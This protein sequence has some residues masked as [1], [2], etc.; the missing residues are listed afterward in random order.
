M[1]QKVVFDDAT[2]L[3]GLGAL[4]ILPLVAA[5][6]ILGTL[7]AG[8]RA[9][10]ALGEDV[11]RMLEVLA[12]QAAQAVLRAQLFEQTERLAT[13]DALTSLANRRTFQIRATQTLAQARRYG[14]AC[15][16]LMTDIDHFKAGNDTYGHPDGDVVL[17]GVAQMLREQARDTDVVA[18]YGGEE[19]AVVMPE[20]DLRGA[21][22]IAERLREAVAARVFHTEFGPVRVTLSIGLAASPQDGTEM[23]ALVQLADQ[24]LYQA[25]RAGRNRVVTAESSR[26]ARLQAG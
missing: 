14:R 16:V 23:E 21:Q 22:V 5:D 10:G 18:R 26:P 11:I 15:A 13:T 6:R 7:V 4:R 17:R 25:K 1:E 3:R 9:R 20:T 24:S 2:E 19:F 12:I 8:T